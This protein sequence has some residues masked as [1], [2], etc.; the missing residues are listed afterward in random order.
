MFYFVCM[1]IFFSNFAFCFHWLVATPCYV[2]SWRAC[3]VL[4][5]TPQILKLGGGGVQI[6]F[7]KEKKTPIKGAS[8]KSANFFSAAFS[9]DSKRSLPWKK[10]FTP[11][12]RVKIIP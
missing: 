12:W 4:F 11:T 10:A 6:N 1:S 8:E 2:A 9:G 7:L 3:C 5:M